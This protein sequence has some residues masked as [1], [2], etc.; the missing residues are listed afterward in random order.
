MIHDLSRKFRRCSDDEDSS[1]KS[2]FVAPNSIW[3]E[4][5]LR[6]INQQK[7]IRQHGANTNDLKNTKGGGDKTQKSREVIA[8][9]S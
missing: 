5:D 9:H 6:N 1:L 3:R 8:F 7:Q 4:L 2:A